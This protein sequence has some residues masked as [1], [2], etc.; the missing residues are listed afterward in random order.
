MEKVME[1]IVKF[2]TMILI[3][4]MIVNLIYEKREKQKVQE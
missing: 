1:N 4:A 2:I 3:I